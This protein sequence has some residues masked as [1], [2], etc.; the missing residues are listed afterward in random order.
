MI[1]KRNN[2]LK[3]INYIIA[4][5]FGALI[6]LSCG[7]DK[8]EKGVIEPEPMVITG[9]VENFTDTITEFSYYTYEFLNDLSKEE[10]EFDEEGNFRM[11]LNATHP[12]KGWFSLGKI[13]NTEV[14][15]YTTIEGEETK[16]QAGTMDF[17]MFYVF[18]EP[19]DSIH[20]TL[21]AENIA[22]TLKFSGEGEENNR[23]VNLEEE[24]YNSYKHRFLKNWYDVSNREPNDYKNT[25]D[26][27]RDEKLEFLEK[28]EKSGE[29]SPFLIQ[30]YRNSYIGSAVGSKINYP[31]IHASYNDLDST[32]LRQFI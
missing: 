24:T 7:E 16:H 14:F 8:E 25:V 28:H 26:S 22:E 19:G 6:F 18:L 10:V 4:L 5:L 30:W 17:R 3:N 12:I 27:L 32:E 21:D 11:E 1:K 2:L 23:F 13:P 31:S 15:T 29:I 20:I 9:K